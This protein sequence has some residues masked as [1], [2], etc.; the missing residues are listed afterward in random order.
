MQGDVRASFLILNLDGPGLG[1]VN[2]GRLIKL[3]SGGVADLVIMGAAGCQH[4][5]RANPVPKHVIHVH[6]LR[7]LSVKVLK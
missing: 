2:F 4:E 5:H 6:N 3:G 1:R 7:L